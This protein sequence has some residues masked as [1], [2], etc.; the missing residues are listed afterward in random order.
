MPSD[1]WLQHCSW[2]LTFHKVASSFADPLLHHS[3]CL[4]IIWVSQELQEPLHEREFIIFDII[5]LLSSSAH[6][7]LN[8][9]SVKAEKRK[10]TCELPRETAEED[11][12]Y[13][14]P[15]RFINHCWTLQFKSHKIQNETITKT[16]GLYW[17]TSCSLVPV[18]VEEGSDECDAS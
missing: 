6:N 4:A 12:N 13:K 3:K 16:M 18:S 7:K 11:K 5:G 8:Q 14:V 9:V 10:E 17:R 2:A 1:C 15:T